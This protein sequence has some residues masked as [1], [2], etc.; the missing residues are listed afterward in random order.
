MSKRWLVKRKWLVVLEATTYTWAAAIGGVL[1]CKK[2]P[3]NA[4]KFSL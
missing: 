1:V 4:E 2:E 3:A